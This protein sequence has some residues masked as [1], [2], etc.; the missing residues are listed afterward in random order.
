VV[1]SEGQEER[2]RSRHCAGWLKAAASC[3]HFRRVAG[4]TPA[5]LVMLFRPFD[6][7]PATE[8]QILLMFWS[9]RGDLNARPPAPKASERAQFLIGKTHILKAL[10][11]IV[12][13]ESRAL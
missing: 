3:S 13:R 9:G 6:P 11:A 7:S 5:A 10:L 8:C 1:A 2:E 4:E 12:Y